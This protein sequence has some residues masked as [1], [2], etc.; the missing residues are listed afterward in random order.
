[1]RSP[2]CL[3]V[4]PINT[5][6]ILAGKFFLQQT[7]SLFVNKYVY[8][9]V[10]RASKRNLVE[11]HIQDIEITYTWKTHLLLHE[12]IL[13]SIALFLVFLAVIIYVRLDF[14]IGRPEHSKKE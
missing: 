13:V 4:L 1:M 14:S 6:I 10:I 2:D 5:L 9:T 3:T 12:P 11:Q 8:R 7:L